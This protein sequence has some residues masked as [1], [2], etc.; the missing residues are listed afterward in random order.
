MM[1]LHLIF[2]VITFYKLLRFIEQVFKIIY[3]GKETSDIATHLAL[4][5]HLSICIIHYSDC[6]N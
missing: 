3:D 2:V 6:K 1:L 5:R 4:T